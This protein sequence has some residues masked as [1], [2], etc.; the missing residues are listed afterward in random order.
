MNRAPTSPMPAKS[1]RHQESNRV[2]LTDR[3]SAATVPTMNSG[4]AK[5]VAER[6]AGTTALPG[7]SA[8]AFYYWFVFTPPAVLAGQEAAMR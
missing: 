1:P 5:P 3:Q 4:A 2:L 6:E 8:F 7:P